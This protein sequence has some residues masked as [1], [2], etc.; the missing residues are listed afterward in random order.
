MKLI[1][2]MRK[3]QNGKK[4]MAYIKEKANQISMTKADL[5]EVVIRSTR[6]I[7]TTSLTTLEN[8]N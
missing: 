5:I 1:N 8:E 3:L 6:H 2:G 4:Y 7:I